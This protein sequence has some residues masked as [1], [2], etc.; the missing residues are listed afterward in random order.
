MPDRRPS[1]Q[2]RRCR[3]G[4]SRGLRPRTP[5][6][7][8]RR[9]LRCRRRR[10]RR[11]GAAAPAPEPGRSDRRCSGAPLRPPPAPRGCRIPGRR[12]AERRARLSGRPLLFDYPD[13]LR[14]HVAGALDDDRIAGA[15]VPLRAIS[16]SLWSVARETVTPPTCTGSS[17]ATGVSAPVRP[18]EIEMRCRTVSACSAG[19]LVGD[20]PAGRPPGGAQTLLPVETVDLEDDTVNLEVERGPHSLDL[21]DGARVPRRARRSVGR[22]GRARTPT[23]RAARERRPGAPPA[24]RSPRPSRGRRSAAGALR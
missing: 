11:N 18:T 9:G 1:P 2:C 8:W 24:P 14:D 13:H 19:K 20:G 21:P 6:S 16:S 10:G 12:Q 5:R 4:S 23:P 15:D 3:Q 17:S 7:V 22:A